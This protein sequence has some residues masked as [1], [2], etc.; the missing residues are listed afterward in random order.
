TATTDAAGNFSFANL[1][2]GGNYTVTLSLANYTFAP[3]SQSF[4]D[5]GADQSAAFTGT[6]N[7]YTI[8]GQVT[9]PDGK[10]MAGVALALTG[11][12]SAAATTDAAGSF[13]FAGVA[14]G[15]YTVT[16][17]LT[18]Y[19]FAPASQTLDRLPSAK[20]VVF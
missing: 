19:V 6:L 3:A 9:G 16:P 1:P 20:T 18:N 14:G 12:Q 13:S 2:G 8:S 4:G 15:S 7:R 11:T 10:A 5:L 17:S